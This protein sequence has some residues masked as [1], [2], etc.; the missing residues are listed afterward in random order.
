[1]LTI[2]FTSLWCLADRCGRLED[3]PLRIKAETF[4]YRENIDING[5]LTVL[6][7]LGF[8]HRYSCD[9]VAIIQ[10]IN[11]KKHQNPHKTEKD[12]TLPEYSI[13]I[14]SC[15]LT[16]KEPLNNGSYPADSLLPLTDS[17]NTDS[18]NTEK[19]EKPKPKKIE[20][21]KNE[22]PTQDLVEQ[23]TWNSF[24]ELRKKIKA[25]NSPKAI[26][27]LINE[28][29]RLSS[30]GHDPTEVVNQ[31]IRSSWK[32]VYPLKNK[33]P[34]PARTKLEQTQIN[35]RSIFTNQGDSNNERIIEGTAEFIE[36]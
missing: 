31:S 21:E 16:V 32:D 29:T 9:G 28:L 33:H 30:Q 5:Y 12:S 2:L 8:I 3:R 18:L 17:L 20:P 22:L 4:P 14:C 13:E 10:V 26:N 1:M 25:V 23:E 24:L 27:C 15:P 19:P 7:R 6:E 36:H 34:P 35:A 11:F